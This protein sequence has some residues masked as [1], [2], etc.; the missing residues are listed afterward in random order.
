MPST[1][2]EEITFTLEEVEKISGFSCG[3][4]MGIGKVSIDKVKQSCLDYIDTFVRDKK[5]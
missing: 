5:K 4:G 1:D 3:A 2:K